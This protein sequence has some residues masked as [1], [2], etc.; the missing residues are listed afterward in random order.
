MHI[1][2]FPLGPLETNCYVLSHE[3]K[4]VAVDP[5]GKPTEVL[6]YLKAEGLTL[7]HILNTHLHYDHTYGNKPLA[8]A[9]G[10]A[11]LA[12]EGDK[13]LLSSQLGQGGMM[14][15]PVVESYDFDNL[16][17]GEYEFAGLTCKVFATPGHSSGSLSFYFPEAGACF[18]GDLIFY[19]SV[20]RTDFPGGSF[21][22]LKAS[23]AEK[24]FPLP[25]ETVIYPGHGPETSVRDEM[26]HNPF[27]SEFRGEM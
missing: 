9:A 15:L 17:E 4:A 21:E 16:T 5:G 12:N 22:T 13:E 26:N 27:F 11:I 7:T 23:V 19:R 25:P 1:K 20:G 10:V 18:V 2:T 14:G 8:D 3:D 24:I 6:D